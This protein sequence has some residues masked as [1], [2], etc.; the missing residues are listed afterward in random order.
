MTSAGPPDDWGSAL[1]EAGSFL[2]EAE[3]L[4]VGG[5]G[6]G[7]RLTISRRQRA[8]VVGVARGLSNAEIARE[9]RISPRTVRA[10][11]ET[12]K[13]KVSAGRRAELPY[14]FFRATGISPYQL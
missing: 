12:A 13:A 6:G 1:T 4:E 11:I 10:H 5:T 9:L 7:R 14:A 3:R 8:V 2:G